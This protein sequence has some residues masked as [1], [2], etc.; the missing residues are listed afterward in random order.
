MACRRARL[1]RGVAD[2]AL[3][4]VIAVLAAG[5]A[6]VAPGLARAQAASPGVSISTQPAL[7]PA[8]SPNIYDYATRCEPAESVTAAVSDGN[9]TPV[10]VDQ[11]PVERTS[12]TTSLRI[13]AGQSYSFTV[14]AGAGR[15]TYNVRCLPANFPGYTAQ[16][17]S[18]PQ[19]SY[20]LVTPSAADA[21]APAAPYVALFDSNGVPIWWYSET[22]GTPVDANLTPSGDL[23]WDVVKNVVARKTPPAGPWEMTAGY[24]ES[25]G[26][27]LVVHNLDGTLLN[28]LETVGSPT[29][30]H[31]GL[32]LADGDF[33]MTS[34][35]P[36]TGVNLSPVFYAPGATLDAA[37]QIVQPNGAV[38]YKWDAAN[39]I[40]PTESKRWWTALDFGYPGVPG[41][42]WDYQHID[43]VVPDGEGYLVSLAHDDAVYL[44][45]AG[46]G[47][48][49]WKLGGTKTPQSL[50]I[51][52][53]PDASTDFGA[54]SDA[55]V[56][57]DGTI[58]VF[59]NGIA[60]RRP[61]RVLRFRIDP[62]NRTATLIQT[63]TDPSIVTS[64]CCGS[65]RLLPG[66]D[67]AID[68]GGSQLFEEL[69]PGGQPALSVTF[70][71]P[72]FTYQAVPILPGQLP[73]SALLTGMNQMEPRTPSGASPP[74]LSGLRAFY[75]GRGV[76]VR[77]KLA[78]RGTVRFTIGRAA[79]GQ[80]EGWR[81]APLAAGAPPPV[82]RCTAFTGVGSSFSR[83]GADGSNGLLVGH[84]LGA[85][86]Y[87]LSAT[88]ILGRRRGLTEAAVFRVG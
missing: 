69:T 70:A 15:A 35:A 41:A 29:D 67:W 79:P 20:Y 44:I 54:Q 49:E 63:I 31:E 87:M 84:R 86:K 21:A 8:F 27:N 28:T 76:K 3:I 85:G 22:G 55:Q 10:S 42:I 52:G 75:A 74:A 18:Q 39:L 26:V 56:W 12:F 33:L 23:S 68:W 7:Q 77:F 16:E 57:P 50:T 71:Y 4:L 48:I 59:D 30:F 9:G 51:V 80:V 17:F 43:S 72:Y 78:W 38:L 40:T 6:C 25:S 19:A 88:P 37:F 60:R 46:N 61:P 13:G 58:S 65:A 1:G 2:S 32:P 14:G 83:S 73:L 11:Q 5:A 34:Y 53:D 45:N 36:R 24:G 82:H 64:P 62:Q 47:S 66:G 81:C